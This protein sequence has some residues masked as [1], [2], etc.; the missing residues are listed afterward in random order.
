MP[1][2]PLS[3]GVDEV[4]AHAHKIGHK[5]VDLAIALSAITISVIS[6]VVAVEHGKTE[7]RLVAASSWP[8]LT[9]T[10]SNDG[11][12][13]GGWTIRL[14]LQNSGVGPARV[15][16]LRLA[17]NGEPIRNRGDLMR[18]CCGVPD[19]TVEDQV[20]R[21]LV[22]QNSPIGVLPARESVVVLAWRDRR[23]SRAIRSKLDDAANRLR[24]D[25]CYC[26]VLD[27]CW[28]SDLTPTAEPR[29]V[30]HCSPISDGY[31]S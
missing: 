23:G 30:D 26:S 10:S 3:S 6:L 5:W 4:H 9:F 29:L 13:A 16:W 8:F 1:E 28:V 18:K 22:S 12:N 2:A 14:R 25:A 11:F 17:L 27:E 20:R 7:E 31:V 24:L 15:K 19:G 21:G